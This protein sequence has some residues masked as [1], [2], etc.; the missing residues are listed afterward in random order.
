MSLITLTTFEKCN[1]K[2]LD[3]HS[4]SV[5]KLFFSLRAQTD[6]MLDY[7]SGTGT[8]FCYVAKDA[9]RYSTDPREVIK[10]TI[11]ILKKGLF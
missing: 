5:P 8:L 10:K 4:K 7:R 2:S 9:N 6:K 1:S 11:Q 3:C